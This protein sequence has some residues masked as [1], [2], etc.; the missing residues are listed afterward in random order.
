MPTPNLFK[1]FS[2]KS[3]TPENATDEP[4]NDKDDASRSIV[5]SSENSP[6]AY[7]N[8]LKEAW[9]A[10]HKELPHA[11]GAEKVLD[12]IGGPSY[13][14]HPHRLPSHAVLG[15]TANVQEALTLSSEQQAVVDTFMDT[16][17]IAETIHK[18]VNTFME[19]VPPLMKL[20]DEVAKIHPFISGTISFSGTTSDL[21]VMYP[22]QLLS[23]HSKLY[24][25]SRRNGAR[26]IKGF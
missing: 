26:T 8:T 10:A 20:L 15:R 1:K 5:E 23:L 13:F 21:T 7:S 6:P 18:G 12:K 9:E 16:S 11:R 17:K 14:P 2:L 24:T 19:A 22:V 4:L 25:R 3:S